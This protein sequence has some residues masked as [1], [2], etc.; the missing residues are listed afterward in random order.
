M[1]T[2]SKRKY[3]FLQNIWGCSRYYMAI[4]SVLVSGCLREFE[5]VF[6]Q[7]VSTET[8]ITFPIP[9]GPIG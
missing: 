3:L 1:V 4:S 8:L 5:Q 2:P 6:T 9:I 7:P